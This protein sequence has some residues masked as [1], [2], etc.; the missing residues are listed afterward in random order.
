M[1]T[2]KSAAGG[3]SAAKSP[4]PFP[5]SAGSPFPDK[6]DIEAERI[7]LKDLVELDDFDKVTIDARYPRYLELER[8][9]ELLRSMQNQHAKRGGADAEV[10]STEASIINFTLGNLTN[11]EED[12]MLLHTRESS[13]LFMGRTVEPGRQGYGQS[14]AK[15]V[16][17]ALRAVWY[18]SGNDNPYA[19]FALIEAA[20]RIST[21]VR[22]LEKAI[23]E[24]ED[25]LGQLKKRGLTYSVL[26][27]DPPVRVGLGFRSP[28]GY[29]VVN[30]VSTFD[31]YVRVIKTMVRKDM[32][33]DK[34]GYAEV[35]TQTRRCR[36]IFERV[37]WFQRYLLREEMRPLTRLDWLP[38]ADEEA[39]KRVQAAVALFGEL[40]REVFNGQVMPRHSRRRL[41]L[42]E[43]E[44]RLL[45]A[46]PLAG[47]DQ[48]LEAATAA[49]V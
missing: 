15:K 5:I 23:T 46:V 9:E 3:K 48:A 42:S 44:L 10:G 22:E 8:R 17:A 7:A 30:L 21:L 33:S 28:Y 35:Y 18:L 37:I 36:S 6:Y 45:D 29:S 2:T 13:R 11:E 31:Y 43:E 16:G 14:G 41:D 27:A 39:R 1:A 38:T 24:M 34:E 19:D 47:A 49:L 32:L 4:P 25:R 20:S 12:A 26:K 40:P